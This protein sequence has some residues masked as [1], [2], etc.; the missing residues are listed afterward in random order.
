MKCA[1]KENYCKDNINIE[2]I[3]QLGKEKSEENLN[4]LLLFYNGILPLNAKNK[5]KII[6]ATLLKGDSEQTLLKI[7]NKTIH[8][9]FTSPPYYNARMY[10]D[11]TSYEKYLEKMCSIL[12]QCNR[13]LK[14]GHFIIIN[15]SPV[16][17]KRPGREFESV[18]YPIHFDFHKILEEV[19]FYFIDEIIWIKPEYTVPNR[20]AGYLQTGMPLSYKPN[21]VTE[22]LLVYRK[23]TPFLLD[24][25]IRHYSRMLANAVENTD[26]S[27]CW[28][29][30]ISPKTDKDH[31]AVFPEK[32][33]EKVLKYYSFSGD[34]VLDPFA[35]SGTFG[36]VAKKMKRVPVLCEMDN[37]YT[38]KLEEESYDNL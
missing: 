13:I 17:T 21:C 38:K 20:I 37:K 32:L 6:K 11:Y 35:G 4:K 19:G 7:Q 15:V 12:K 36:R 23:K 27:N 8:F 9:I 33:C 14:D 10:S 1:L 34:T 3:K 28:C 29:W 22:S 5:R 26:T 31:P 24:E 30:Y 18:R 25:N 2:Y 16:I